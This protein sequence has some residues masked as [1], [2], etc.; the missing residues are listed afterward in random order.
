MIIK[1]RGKKMVSKNTLAVLLIVLVVVSAVGATL[2]LVDF[3]QGN[4]AGKAQ[5][6]LNVIEQPS[7]TPTGAVVKLNVIRKQA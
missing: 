1:S 2:L 7:P 4:E 6:K 3:N 5:V